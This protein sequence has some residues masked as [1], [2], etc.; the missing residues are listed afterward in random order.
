[1]LYC[2]L[3]Q[4]NTIKIKKELLKNHHK[5]TEMC[6]AFLVEDT[7]LLHVCLCM[8]DEI[9]LSFFDRPAHFL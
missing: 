7:P 3:I 4:I 5:I 8:P 1:M 2:T 9:Q 6:K